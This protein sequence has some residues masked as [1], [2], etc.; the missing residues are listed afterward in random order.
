MAAESLKGLLLTERWKQIKK[1]PGNW[2]MKFPPLLLANE[3]ERQKRG[4]ETKRQ[5]ER[6]EKGRRTERERQRE[7][8]DRQHRCDGEWI[9]ENKHSIVASP[10][11]PQTLAGSLIC[12]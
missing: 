1:F 2:V 8:R 12:V 6:K 11:I 7:R 10:S 9:I 3:K 4:R 5:R